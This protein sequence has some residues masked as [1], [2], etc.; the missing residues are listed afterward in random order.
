MEKTKNLLEPSVAQAIESLVAVQEGGVASRVIARSAGGNVTLFAFDAG[1]EL[2]EHSAPFD[3]LVQV[4][5]G[6]LDLTIGGKPVAVEAGQMVLMPAD[7][8]HALKA[9]VRTRMILVMLRQKA[10]D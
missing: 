7:I 6:H 3:A 8:P 10:A 9:P 5:S 4:V 2:S 1:E